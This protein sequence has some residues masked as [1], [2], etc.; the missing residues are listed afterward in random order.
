MKK[1]KFM[2]KIKFMQ[3]KMQCEIANVVEK[4]HYNK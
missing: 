1:S 2:K 4:I 3:M